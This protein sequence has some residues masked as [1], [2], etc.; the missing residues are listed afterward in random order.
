MKKEIK[1][2]TLSFICVS[3]SLLFF[4]PLAHSTDFLISTQAD[5]DS[6]RE[7][8]FQP[9]D[10]ILLERGKVFTGMLAPNA[11]G[12]VENVITI[13]AYG[14]G[15][16]P[17]INNNGVIHPHPVRAS[18]TV[19]AGIL[20]FNA[21]YV[22]LSSIE[23]TNNNGGDQTEDLFGI[24]V[25]AEDTG[26][27]H[28]HIYI[29]DTYVH[30]VNGA[31]AGKKRGGIHVHGYSP[32]TANAATYNDVRIVNNVIDQIG[33]VGIGTDID[34][35]DIE[36]AHDFAG[37]HRDNAI[38]NLY[39]AHNWV[40]NTGRNSVVGRDSDYAIYE[41]N[42]SAYSSRHSTGNSF[43][44][45]KTIGLVF[46]YNEAYGNT[47]ALG[48]HDRGGFDADY[49]SKGTIIQYNYS[50]GN[51]WF[52]SIMKKPMTDTIIRYNLS[53]NDLY[54]AYHYGFENDTDA[55]NTEIYN[56]T[57][58]FRKG[59]S[60]EII[61][62][63]L[64]RTPLET[65][66][67]NNIFFSESA[68]TM[69]VNAENGINVVYDTNVYYNI[70]PPTSEVNAF[71]A[72]PQFVATGAEPYDVDMENG[73]DA[74]AGYQLASTSPYTA[75]GRVISNNGGLD[76]WGETVSP[77][78][79]SI[80]AS[81]PSEF[82]MNTGLNDAWYNPVTDGQGFFITVFPDL[83]AVSLAW[84][85][86]DTELPPE[87][88]SANLGDAG[89]RWMTAVGAIDGNTSV[90][91]IEFTSGGL[92]DA[93]SE[94]QATNPVGSDGTITL[95]FT[96]CASGLVEYDIKSIDR[97]GSVPIQRVADDNVVLCEVLR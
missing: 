2:L 51:H 79:S 39:V 45:F 87:D 31:V 28:N 63:K 56:N 16:K 24:Y 58:Y 17:I 84:F 3:L 93:A 6:Y 65:V 80:G 21:E 42:T 83:G 22:E 97:Q 10:N 86:Y 19:S 72:D 94:I 18:S 48:D 74:L 71:T 81:A 62:P 41:Y 27:A 61:G 44:N 73:R 47:G 70:T 23:V 85:T 96:D 75:N 67:N 33:G 52:A 43:Y 5:F 59:I 49:Y 20:L 66:F 50:H 88:A 95:S 32:A 15:P 78:I 76:F 91:D 68:G 55:T 53:V 4:A 11:V 46:Q 77:G 90:M 35:N 30:H 36:R 60:P 12:T 82:V 69:G 89:H 54:G 13:S 40:G 7:A 37:T 38:T 57:H 26:K 25:L 1:Q 34:D 14:D 29:E 64:D 92:F 9:G 8:N